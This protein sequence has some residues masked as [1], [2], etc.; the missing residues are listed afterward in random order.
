M[1]QE[2]F[3]HEGTVEYYNERQRN[4]DI[5][6]QLPKNRQQHLQVELFYS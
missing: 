2:A 1:K 3:Y 4:P 6:L 5:Y